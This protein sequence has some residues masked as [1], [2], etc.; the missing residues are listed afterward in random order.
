[1][2]SVNVKIETLKKMANLSEIGHSYCYGS[3]S[4]TRTCDRV[5]NSHQ[6]Y[7]LSYPGMIGFCLDGLMK[8]GWYNYHI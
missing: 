3:R 2:K 7:R 5:V 6:L 8:S 4:R 1:M